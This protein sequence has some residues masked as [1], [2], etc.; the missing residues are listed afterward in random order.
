MAS[1]NPFVDENAALQQE[2]RALVIFG[3]CR[4]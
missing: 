3:C 1:S 4:G 2:L